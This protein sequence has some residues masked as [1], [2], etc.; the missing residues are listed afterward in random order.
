MGNL[1]LMFLT[2]AGISVVSLIAAL[3]IHRDTGEPA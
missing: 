3:I 2:S 1:E